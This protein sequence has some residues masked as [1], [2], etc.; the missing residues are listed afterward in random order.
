MHIVISVHALSEIPIDIQRYD[1]KTPR[2]TGM[3]A[4]YAHEHVKTCMVNAIM[5]L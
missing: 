5:R 3:T 2:D 4:R 1:Y